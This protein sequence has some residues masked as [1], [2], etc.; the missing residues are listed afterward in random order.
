MNGRTTLA[1]LAQLWRAGRATGSTGR[2]ESLA[3]AM[4][5]ERL[6]H[7]CDTDQF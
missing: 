6:G 2:P 3:V 5:S 4:G 7:S 1:A